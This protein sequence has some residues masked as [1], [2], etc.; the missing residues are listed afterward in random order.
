LEEYVTNQQYQRQSWTVELDLTKD[1]FPVTKGSFIAYSGNTGGSQGPHLHFEIIETA[2]DKRY[3]PLLFSFP[4][5]DDVPPTITKLAIYDRSRSVYGQ[6]PAFYPVKNTDTGYIIPKM[7]VI[8]TGLNKLSFAIQTYDRLSGSNNPNG[9][10]KASVQMD[11]QEY[12]S[13]KLDHISYEETVYM[14]AQVDYPMRYNGGAYIQH[15]SPLPGDIGPVYTRTKNDGVI[16]LDDT[17]VHNISI[18]TADPYGNTSQLQF[19]IQFDN[20]L[21]RGSNEGPSSSF[22]PN[23]VNHFEKPGFEI[24]FEKNALYDTVKTFYLKG[25]SSSPFSFSGTYQVND[26]SVPLHDDIIVRIKPE[27]PVPSEWQDKL[28]IQR[29]DRKGRTVRRAVWE[30]KWLSAKFG[31]L[32]TFQLL[33]DTISPQIN[34]P[35]KGDTVDL[36]PASRIIFTPTDNS[37]IRKFRAEL[38]GQWIRFTNDKSRSWIYIFD[39]R[40]PYGVH[41]LKVTVEDIV[42]NTTTKSWWFKRYPY[43]PPPKKKAA[44][45][46]SKAS[47]SKKKKKK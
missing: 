28:I 16:S 37:G 19:S 17:L 2:T 26:G 33:A 41:E 12:S 10:Y 43:T 15:L 4:L 36:S 35:G 31:D 45:K 38:D 20:D 47:K 8:K 9:I 23:Q 3:N 27:R 21:V 25:A 5:S 32:G 40:C 24:Y 1:Q 44:K 34:D 46:S 29:T 42:G 13:F 14:D 7:P 39:E 30:E 18:V 11:G 6:S 22:I